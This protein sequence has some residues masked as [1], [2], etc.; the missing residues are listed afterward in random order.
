[1]LGDQVYADEVS[2]DTLRAHPLAAR[3]EQA[4]RRDDRRLRGVH[5]AVP[6]G[7]DRPADPLAA[8][9]DAV[10][11]DLRRPRRH[12]RLEHVDRLAGGDA[13]HRLVGSAR[14]RRLHGLRAVPALRQPDP[15]HARGGAGLPGGCATRAT[16]AT[17]WRPPPTS[18]I[19]R[20]RA[21]RWSYCRDV[22]RTRIVMIDSRAGRV[23]TPGGRSMVDAEE[24]R[25][26]LEHATGGF[27]HLVIGT[28]LP[29]IMAPGL[30]YLEA[31]NEAVCDGAW[32]EPASRLGEKIR[33]GADLEHWP[34]FRDSFFAMCE[35]LREVGAGGRGHAPASVVV[36]LGRRAPRLPRRG[37]LPGR[38]RRQL[39][40]LAGHVLAVPQPAERQGAARRRVHVQPHRKGGRAGAGPARR[41]SATAD[42]LALPGRR[43]AVRQPGRHAGA[44]WPARAGAA[45][46]RGGRRHERRDPTSRSP[47]STRSPNGVFAVPSDIADSGVHDDASEPSGEATHLVT[48]RTDAELIRSAKQD[49]EAFREFYD[50]YAVWIRSWFKRHTGSES[51]SLDLTAET[52]AQAWHSSRRFQDLADGPVPRGCSGSP[53]TC[54]GSTTSTT[55]SS[56]PHASAWASRRR[57]PT[58]TTTS[59]STTAARPAR[60]R[61]SCGTRYGPCPR[62]SAARSSCGS[63]TSSHMTRS[64]AGWAAPRTPRGCAS[65]AP[66]GR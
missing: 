33:Q 54:C 66:S 26:I 37:R 15:R 11:D 53:A 9:H 35:L 40:R 42:A 46:A 17:S 62:I 21:S 65:H 41:R 36:R 34:A 29:L 45:R 55:A 24:W 44:R 13:R 49:P 51:A 19:A 28:S 14:R 3:H 25:W 27:D 58:A 18:G 38:Q 59:A 63:C 22:G 48:S 8:V 61:R 52:F 7:V 23:L 2:P 31:W 43:P 60:W 30:H 56:R 47:T 50:R 6:G 10:G 20:S 4:A 64:P 32:G 39:A 16:A 12:R 5:A 1:M 57:A